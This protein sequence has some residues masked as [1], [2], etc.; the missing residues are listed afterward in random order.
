M[1]E[2]ELK[3]G[4]HNYHPIPVAI[5]KGEGVYV[6]DV[7]GKKYMDFLSAYSSLNQGH[8]HPKI[9]KALIEQLN[10]LTLTSRAYYT[11]VLG[12]Y[13]QYMTS[14]FGYDKLLPMNT[15]VE[16][17]ETAVK[18]VRRWG[19]DIKGIPPNQAKMVFAEGNFWGRSL[20]AI[21]S[22][23]DAESYGGFG[24]YVPNFVVIPYNN[25]SALEVNSNNKCYHGNSCYRRLC[26]IHV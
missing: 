12:E 16:A 4:A 23:T 3:Y 17:C 19:Y 14:I 1:I 2:R 9:V 5:A 6:W 8:R 10:V 25:L 11:D 15:G 24:P 26:R 7:E 13:E 22:S 20:A 18:L 21:S